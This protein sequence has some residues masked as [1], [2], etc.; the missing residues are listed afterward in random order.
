MIISPEY[1]FFLD[2]MYDRISE[3]D[4]FYKILK[5]DNLKYFLDN[6]YYIKEIQKEFPSIVFDFTFPQTFYHRNEKFNITMLKRVTTS[7]KTTKSFLID[8]YENKISRL[9]AFRCKNIKTEYFYSNLEDSQK[10]NGIIH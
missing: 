9:V 6:S 4:L 10:V 7:L 8:Y 3:E 5:N 1:Q 2:V